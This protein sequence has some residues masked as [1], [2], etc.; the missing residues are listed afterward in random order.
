MAQARAALAPWFARATPGMNAT[1]HEELVREA[2]E[3]CASEGLIPVEWLSSD[4]RW[5]RVEAS[6][7]RKYSDQTLD[8]RPSGST[9][10]LDHPP[11][12]DACLAM[13]SDASG[14]A[15]AEELGRF[16]LDALLAWVPSASI[17]RQLLWRID[18]FSAESNGGLAE[19]YSASRQPVAYQELGL[20][21]EKA[22][23]SALGAR[24][25]AGW[26]LFIARMAR[27]SAYM[28][29]LLAKKVTQLNIDGSDVPVPDAPNPFHRA[30][31][32]FAMGYGIERSRTSGHLR[33][34]AAPVR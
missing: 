2:W 3:C 10:I 19:V 34:L 33:L 32:L 26:P 5:A 27:C 28:D 21:G 25:P 18:A 12:L 24:A 11:T 31:E 6:V 30:A 7:A 29:I 23:A 4:R 15:A 17:A 14:V 22:F 13:A 8:L 9:V 16:V 20:A 1:E